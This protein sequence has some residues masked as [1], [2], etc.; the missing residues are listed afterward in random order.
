MSSTGSALCGGAPRIQ[1]TCGI[2]QGTIGIVQ[3]TIS[4]IHGTIGDV[5][6]TMVFIQGTIFI[7]TNNI[8]DQ[9]TITTIVLSLSLFILRVQ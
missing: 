2:I 6:G 9:I 8:N 1:E 5:Q 3:G 7:F 4:I